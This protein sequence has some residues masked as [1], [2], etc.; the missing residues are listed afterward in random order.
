VST[1]LLCDVSVSLVSLSLCLFVSLSLS[2]SLVLSRLSLSSLCNCCV[3]TLASSTSREC[4]CVCVCVRD[5]GCVFV[6]TRAWV[7]VTHDPAL[8]PKLKRDRGRLHRGFAMLEWTTR[9][10]GLG[11]T[12]RTQ[13]TLSA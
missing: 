12:S 4:V 10:A 11:C 2:R 6:L 8:R 1:R 9:E 13:L 3:Y 7:C 5:D